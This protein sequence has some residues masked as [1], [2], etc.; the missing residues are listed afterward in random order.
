MN[1]FDI[2]GRIHLEE[3]RRCPQDVFALARKLVTINT[4]IFADRITPRANRVSVFPIQTAG[5]DDDDAEAAWIVEDVRR[6]QALH[7]HRW[8]DVAL[9]YRKHDIGDRLEAAFLNAGIPCRLP[10]G[11]ALADDPV[12]A[13]VLAAARVIAFPTD[14]LVR[15]AFFRIVLPRA[16]FEEAFAKAEEKRTD[17]RL[18]LRLMGRQLPRAD[19]GARQIRRALADWKNL[20]AVG[21]QHSSLATLVHGAAVAA[22]GQGALGARRPARRDQR[23]GVAARCRRAR[24]APPRRARAPR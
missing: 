6:D 7:G 10:H 8:G 19:D 21:K 1:D 13:Y 15:D 20:E 16:L 9:L 11:R 4:P 14:D 22:R 18:Q 24:R 12:V 3:N 17:L 2:A 5:F 23:S